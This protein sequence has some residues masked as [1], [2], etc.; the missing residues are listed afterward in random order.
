M[1]TLEELPGLKTDLVKINRTRGLYFV[2]NPGGDKDSDISRYT[3]AFVESDTRPISEQHSVL[4]KAPLPSSIRVETK[5]SVHAYWLLKPGGTEAQWRQMQAGLLAHFGGDPAIKN[6]SRVMRLPFFKHVSLNGSGLVYKRVELR[7]FDPERRYSAEE[8]LKAFP[9]PQDEPGPREETKGKNPGIYTTWD[10]LNAELRRRIA[11]HPSAAIRPDGTIHSQ[12]VCHAGKSIGKAGALILFPG[13]GAFSCTSGCETPAI[14]KA[15]GLPEKPEGRVEVDLNSGSEE[16]EA[17]PQLTL[18]PEAFQGILGDIVGTIEPHT[19]AD[20]A[21]L[22]AQFLVALGNLIGF[23]PYVKADGGLHGTNLFAV[24]VGK[25]SKAR[26]GT[27]WGWVHSIMKEVDEIWE[28]K[29]IACGLSS[30]EGLI[31]AVRDPL[32]KREGPPGSRR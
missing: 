22:L 32:E 25:S 15:F 30:G 26:K 24:L 4:D 31:Y 14:L 5:K 28:S 16:E 27:S 21:A 19:E 12:G 1:A 6:P 2:V 18:E 9:A 23:G 11:A 20:P 8:L 7:Q 17:S 10:E 13:T 29:R 3:A